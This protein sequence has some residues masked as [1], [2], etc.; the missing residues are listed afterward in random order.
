VTAQDVTAQDVTGPDVT[1]PGG[2]ALDVEGWSCP[3]PLRDRDRIVMGHGGGGRLTAELVEH[4]FLP[5]FGA[6]GPDGRATAPCSRSAAR[7]WPSRPTPTS[8]SR[9]SSPAAASA[10]WPSTAP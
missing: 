3:L 9:C 1:G 5:A 6:A 4:L 7:A 8:S 2:A 10:T